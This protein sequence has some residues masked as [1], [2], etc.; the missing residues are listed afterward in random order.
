M[1]EVV[2]VAKVRKLKANKYYRNQNNKNQMRKI[3]KKT[4]EN[5]KKNKNKRL[6][7]RR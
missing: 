6:I 5:G 7:K 3:K 4:I 2:I 1:G